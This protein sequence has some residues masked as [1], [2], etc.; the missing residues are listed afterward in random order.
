MHEISYVRVEFVG[1][2]DCDSKKHFSARWEHSLS[3]G[4]KIRPAGSLE[5]NK[6]CDTTLG[7][8]TYLSL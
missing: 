1:V 8:L 2:E 4:W 3:I 5:D 7:C 6:T